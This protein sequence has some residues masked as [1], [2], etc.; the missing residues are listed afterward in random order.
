MSSEK[1]NAVPTA[2]GGI[3]EGAESS[4]E[5]APTINTASAISIPAAA[6]FVNRSFSLGSLSLRAFIDA[7]YSA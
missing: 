5:V 3:T 6:F 1:A 7:A 2:V 4:G